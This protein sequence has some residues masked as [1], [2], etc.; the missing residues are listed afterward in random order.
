MRVISGKYKGKY[1]EGF[2]IDGTRPT[3]DRVKE[4]IFGSIQNKVRNSIFLD[5]FAGSG[6][7]GI[8]ALSNGASK[9][10]FVENGKDI[11]KILVKN[12][13]D[14]A[15]PDKSDIQN[16]LDIA[17]QIE[18]DFNI[19]ADL[20]DAKLGSLVSVVED[21][22]AQAIHSEREL[23]KE[24]KA[25]NPK[26]YE[27]L[28]AVFVEPFATTDDEKKLLEKELQKVVDYVCNRI[29]EKHALTP[30]LPAIKGLKKDGVAR[31]LIIEGTTFLGKSI[32]LSSIA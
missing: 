18:T 4:S 21:K 26:L 15:D 24:L 25:G 2:D 13:T 10:Y 31:K 7:I 11:Y 5:L 14:I 20:V 6:S 29:D 28:R 9:C 22:N 23:Y 1:I 16:E 8:E 12:L 30:P 3:K 17:N 19:D 27:Q 32:D